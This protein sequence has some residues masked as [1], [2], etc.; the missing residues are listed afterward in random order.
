M[1]KEGEW[2]GLVVAEVLW[3]DAL[4]VTNWSYRHPVAL[5]FSLT[6]IH[7]TLSNSKQTL[8]LDVQ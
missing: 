6:T 7:S 5:I 2:S 4:P 1:V 3:P 8:L